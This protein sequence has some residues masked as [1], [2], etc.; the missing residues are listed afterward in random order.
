MTDS[1]RQTVLYFLV[2]IVSLFTAV[3]VSSFWLRPSKASV[4]SHLPSQISSPRLAQNEVPPPPPLPDNLGAPAEVA[5]PQLLAPSEP[6]AAFLEPYLYDTREG[7]RNPFKPATFIEPGS[8]NNQMVG[9]S[10]PLERFELDELRLLAIIWDVKSPRAM[11]LDP[12]NE[13]H[14]VG[15]DDRIGRR[16]GYI[17]VIREGEVVVVESSTYGGEPVYSTRILRMD[18]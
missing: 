16:R 5:V 8:L 15:K 14:T 3:Y 17:A 12:A 9:P 18:K 11:F 6:A 1:I 13:V 2:G 7:R 10:T 4:P